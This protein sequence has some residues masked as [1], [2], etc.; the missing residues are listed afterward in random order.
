MRY[1]T[2]GSGVMEDNA[3]LSTAD[4]L[5]LM[6]DWYEAHPDMPAPYNPTVLH[7]AVENEDAA[8]SVARALGTFKK[9]GDDTFL[10][11]TKTFGSIP[12]EFIFYRNKVCTPRVV[13]TETVKVMKLDPKAPPPPM[14][15]VEETRDVIVW[16]CPPL[17]DDGRA[18]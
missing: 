9:F 15:E 1:G 12:L 5:R 4:S 14:V 10:R 17:L 6:A 11:L 2:E 18:T 16:D 8:A 7:F 13:K 3:K